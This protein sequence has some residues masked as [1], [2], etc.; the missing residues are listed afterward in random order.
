M[1]KIPTK[2]RKILK[3]RLGSFLKMLKL[4]SA[5]LAD[6]KAWLGSARQKVGSGASLLFYPPKVQFLITKDVGAPYLCNQ[7]VEVR[8][9]WVQKIYRMDH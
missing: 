7:R 9:Q 2:F 1:L 3:A 6:Q 4:G 5:R 8:T